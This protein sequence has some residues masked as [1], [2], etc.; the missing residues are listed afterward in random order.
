MLGTVW[1]SNTHTSSPR[2][3]RSTRGATSAY[4]FGTRPSNMSGGSTTWSSTL[5]KIMSLTCM[6]PRYDAG[7]R[8]APGGSAREADGLA[9]ARRVVGEGEG[10]AGAAS[11][12]DDGH[13]AR[14]PGGQGVGG[15]AVAHEGE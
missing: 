12:G 7:A 15:A 11:G 2:S 5:M 1:P 3:L 6:G 9:A 4:F 8:D 13:R 10:A 14:R